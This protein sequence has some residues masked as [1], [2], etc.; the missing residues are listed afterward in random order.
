MGRV[1]NVEKTNI[2]IRYS[3]KTKRI[4]QTLV[5]SVRDI[6]IVYFVGEMLINTRG[7]TRTFAR[8][9]NVLFC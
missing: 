3:V 9:G 4:E 1:S 2:S 7:A 6:S 8:G 5:R